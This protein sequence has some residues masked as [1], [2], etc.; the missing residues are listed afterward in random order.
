MLGHE[1]FAEVSEDFIEDDFNLTGLNSQ[2]PMYKEALEMILDVE[3]EEDDSSGADDD[4][5][6]DA[7]DDVD[8]ADDADARA[9]RAEARRAERRA[10]RLQSDL[11]I[12]ESSAELLYGLIHQRYITSRPGIGQM[13][14][15]YEMGHFGQCPWPDAT[16]IISTRPALPVASQ[17]D[18]SRPGCSSSRAITYACRALMHA[19]HKHNVMV[20][21]KSNAAGGVEPI[22]C[23]HHPAGGGKF[24]SR[25]QWL[26][27]H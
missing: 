21:V 26:H 9:A 12:I 22:M 27:C 13:H 3:P 11:S 18:D 24:S 6:E 16:G 5:D 1:Y 8:L 17:R 4:E 7:S 2:V 25:L 23:V 15:K 20:A 14:E 19:E 10:M